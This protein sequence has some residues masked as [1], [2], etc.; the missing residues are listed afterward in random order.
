MDL[1][2]DI[3]KEFLIES[4]ENLDRLDQDLMALEDVPDDRNRLSSVFR[5]IHTIKGTSGFLAFNKLEHVTHVGESLLVMLRDGKMRLNNVIA[6]GLLAMVD[7]VRKI[8]ASIESGQGEGDTDYTELVATLERLQVTGG[9][10]V[11]AEAPAPTETERV[12]QILEMVA[13]QVE[14]MTEIPSSPAVSVQEVVTT[15]KPRATTRRRKKSGK[16]SECG[17]ST[18]VMELPPKSAW[19]AESI[20]KQHEAPVAIAPAQRPAVLSESEIHVTN[21]PLHH[22]LNHDTVAKNG[23]SNEGD[24]L[25]RGQPSSVSDSTIRIDVTLL[26][27]LMNLVGELVLARNQIL[28]YSRSTEDA[29]LIAASQRLNL[30]TTELQ[31]GVMKTRMQPIQNVWAKLPRVVRDL[32]MTCKKKVQVKMEGADTELDKTILEAIRDPL[33]HIVRNS[34]DHG[35]ESPEVREAKGKPA[36]GTLLLRAFH[37]GGQ[38]NIEIRDDGGG[39]NLARVKEKGIS[40]NLITPDQAAAMSDRELMNLI[41]LPGFSTAAA[42]TNV[43]GRGVGMDVVKTN[44]EKIGGTLEIY[45]DFGVGTTLRIK[46]PLTLAIVPALMVTAGQERYAIPQNSLVELVRLEGDRARRDIEHIHEAPVYRLRGNLLPL[47]YL[48]EQLQLRPARSGVELSQESVVNI[49]VLNAEDRQFGLVVDEIN[50]TEEIVVKPL[51]PHLK[52][53]TSYAGVTIMGD[54]TVSLILD[55]LGIAKRAHIVTSSRDRHKS[56]VAAKEPSADSMKH[57]LLLL[58]LGETQRMAI[59]LSL[60]SRLEELPKKSIEWAD[61]KQ[62]VQYSGQIMPLIHLGESLCIGHTEDHTLDNLQVVVY[63]ENGRSVGLVVDRILD[64]V[65]TTLT[66][67]QTGRRPGVLGSSV[68]QNRVTDVLDIH[69]LILATD[70]DFF[71]P[72]PTTLAI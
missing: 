10:E 27:R 52:E 16:D 66:M 23:P 51:G 2:D 19:D 7:A 58:G 31:E 63:S 30:I 36:E 34:V 71:T 46:I 47:L 12:T 53:I 44:V 26:D 33:T 38:V 28:Q 39:I 59:P 65:E 67:Q 60:V 57:T 8:M 15:K 49:V 70:Q 5:A 1:L 35:I 21:E 9:V 18:A 54:G 29:S 32:S 55:V 56:Q 3:V 64:I 42:V 4:Y 14:I 25:E 17:A 11:T 6:N 45:S 40:Q 22:D 20:A 68:I 43:S 50:D 13:Q 24:A 72:P 69:N 41:L 62:V 37:E 48:D 61:G